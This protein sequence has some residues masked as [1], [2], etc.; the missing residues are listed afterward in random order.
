MIPRSYEP[1]CE[2]PEIN[3]GDNGGKCLA[4]RALVDIP[5]G[6]ECSVFFQMRTKSMKK[7]RLILELVTS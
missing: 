3:N 4:L 5:E 2:L 1:N 7:L 6:E